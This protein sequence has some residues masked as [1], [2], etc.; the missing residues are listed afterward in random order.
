MVSAK[1]IR[2]VESGVVAM[3]YRSETGMKRP[4][5][6]ASIAFA[7]LKLR[8][9]GFRTLRGGRISPRPA[10]RIRA[11]D[12]HRDLSSQISVVDARLGNE[13]TYQLLPSA[14]MRQGGFANRVIWTV[15]LQ[16]GVDEGASRLGACAEGV[17]DHIEQRQDHRLAGRF[18]TTAS[19]RLESW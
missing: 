1:P 15:D 7:A 3:K 10:D 8:R 6:S 13:S 16:R 2:T 17:L 12:Q 19:I 18:R 9:C 14:K 5:P 4:L 11:V